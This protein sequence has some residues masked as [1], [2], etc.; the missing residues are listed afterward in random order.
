MGFPCDVC[1]RPDPG[2]NVEQMTYDDP[3]GIANSLIQN[4]GIDR[5]VETAMS[6]T[7]AAG[8]EGNNYNL[9]IWR[10]VKYILREHMKNLE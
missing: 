8:R 6:E 10:E 3:T 2:M 5:A 9:S 7:A 1:G 4:L